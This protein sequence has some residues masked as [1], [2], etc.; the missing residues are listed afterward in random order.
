M[1]RGALLPF[2][3]TKEIRPL[4]PTWLACVFALVVVGMRGDPKLY[5]MGLLACA[6]GSVALGAL[7]IGHEYTHRTLA[8]L[9]TQ[10]ASR[11]RLLLIKLAVLAPMLLTLAALAWGAVLNP[12]QD[13]DAGPGGREWSVATVIL[14]P[15]LCALFVAPLLT[16]L[17]RNPLAGIVFTITVPG[18]M[19]LV[20]ELSAIAKYGLETADPRVAD[21]FG[22]AVFWW[23]TVG[24][25]AVAA[26]SNWLVFLRLEAIEGRDAD[27]RLP[28]AWVDRSEATTTAIAPA[29]RHPVWLLVK[30]ELRLQQ[31]AFVVSG[32]YL[33]GWATFSLI[34]NIVP[35]RF[36]PPIGAL[37]I[38]YGGL[39]ALLIGALASAEERHI[40]TLESQVLL[41]MASW[42]QW[43][44]KAG[45]AIA[46]ALAL[47]IGWPV[48]LAFLHPS[49]DDLR[50]NLRSVGAVI[51]LTSSGLY[52]SSL[53]TS[54]VKALLWSIPGMLVVMIAGVVHALSST[55]ATRQAAYL[56]EWLF[57]GLAGGLL[58]L[59]LWFA[60]RNHRSAE[61][62][63]SRV[64]WQAIWM[65]GY[66]VTGV[67]V[68]S[69]ALGY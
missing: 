36:G 59:V 49:A 41:P 12:L 19:H 16:M 27:L 42:R 39:L 52:A 46:L 5:A 60:F 44:V 56:S 63:A 18:L 28:E 22:L 6:L 37:A 3:M 61:R 67:S 23:G 11:Q 24:V 58:A 57:F 69:I 55:V 20:G 34:E 45:T 25:C 15:L 33:F 66:L 29:R 54:G 26:V 47:G 17:C 40:G 62:G 50:V 2:D 21:N 4:L 10:P 43:V 68:M 30:K 64:W 53:C 1:T 38:L 8:L 65:A 35:R 32:I 7:S 51:A 48:L 9:L 14:L 13:L 31:M